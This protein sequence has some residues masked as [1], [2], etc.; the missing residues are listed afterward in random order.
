[1][2]M[3]G[4]IAL[5]ESRPRPLTLEQIVT[6]LVVIGELSISKQRFK[7]IDGSFFWVSMKPYGAPLQWWYGTSESS[8]LE[9]LMIV[10]RT[11]IT[12]GFLKDRLSAPAAPSA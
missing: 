6:E 8:L 1:M 3:A 10:R 7:E 4:K 11:A 5:L 12:R 9:A 2:S